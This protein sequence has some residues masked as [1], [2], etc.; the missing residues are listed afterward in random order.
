MPEM[1]PVVL[2]IFLIRPWNVHSHTLKLELEQAGNLKTETLNSGLQR[3]RTQAAATPPAKRSSN[4]IYGVI[5][6]IIT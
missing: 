6:V 4:Y 2:H 1:L 3:T 5:Y